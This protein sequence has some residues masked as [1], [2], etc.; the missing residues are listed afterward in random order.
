MSD[1]ATPRAAAPQAPLSMGLSRQESWSGS[2][3]PPPVDHVLSELFAMTRLSWVALRGMAHHFTEFCK[4]LHQDKAVTH[5]GHSEDR[6]RKRQASG[7]SG[8]TANAYPQGLSCSGKAASS[9]CLSYLLA[10][11]S[12]LCITLLSSHSRI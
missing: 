10:P 12:L 11:S 8:Q 2:P 5:E 4:P 9:D 3:F 7:G 1:F 6:G